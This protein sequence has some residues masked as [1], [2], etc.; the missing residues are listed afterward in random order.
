LTALSK[1][2]NVALDRDVAKKFK[3]IIM[4]FSGHL[5]KGYTP[6]NRKLFEF[7]KHFNK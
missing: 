3:F 4:V 6:S 1:W 5:L 2:V 7:L